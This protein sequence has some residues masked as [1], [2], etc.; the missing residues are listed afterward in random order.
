MKTKASDYYSYKFRTLL[1]M[2][3]FVFSLGYVQAQTSNTISGRIVDNNNEPV[4]GATVRIVGTTHGVLTDIDG[5]FSIDAEPGATLEVSYIG[6]IPQTIKIGDQKY[7]DLKL[8]EDVKLLEEVVVVGYGVQKKETLTGAVGNLQNDE[9]MKTKAPSLAQ[10]IQGKVAG[11]RI[12]QNNGEPGRFD[13][14]INI[15][16]F[17]TPLFIIDGVLRD[18]AGEF[19]RLNPDDIE[20]ISFLKDATAAI[21]GMNSANGVVIVTTKKG[22]KGKTRFTLNSNLAIS[23]PTSVPKMANAAQYMTM[24]NEAEINA[25]RNPYLTRDELEKWQTGAPGYKSY[26]LYDEVFNNNATQYQTTL[27]V[28]GGSDNISYFGSLGYMTD[29]SV[30]KNDALLYDKYTFRSNVTIKLTDRVTATVNIGG[31]HDTTTRPWFPF[32]DIFK[33]TRVN[34]PL[35]SVYA[36]DNP[37]YYNNFDFVPNPL[38]MIDADYTGN[39]WE[40]NKNLQTLFALEYDLPFVEGLKVKGTFAYDYNDFKNK[41]SRIGFK[42]YTYGEYT[43]EYT[44]I[45][46]NYPSLIQDRR[47]EANRI[48]LQFQT[49]YQRTFNQD[50]NLGATYVFERREERAN[51]M[52]GERK[53]DFYTIGEMDNASETGQLVSGSSEHQAYLSHIGRANYDFKGKYLAELAFRY[54]GS[55]RYAP[56]QRWAFFPFASIGWRM[57]EENFIKDNFGFV[58]NFKIRGSAGRSGQDAGDPF[59]FIPGYRLNHGGYVF[60][61]DT[62]TNGIASPVMINSNLT[63]IQVDMYNVGLDLSFLNRLIAIEFDIYQRTRSGLLAHRYGSLP[64][65]FGATLPQENLNGDRTRGVEFTISHDNKIGDFQYKVSGNFNL[66]RTQ[67]RYIEAGPFKSSMER[68]RGQLAYR[69]N[70]FI[71]GYETDGRFQNMDQ[72]NSYP[73]QNGDNGN[74]KELPGDYILKDKNGDGVVNDLDKTPLFWSGTPQVHFGLNLQASWKNFDFY[75]LLQGAA[76]YTVQFDEVY[77]KMLA[78]RGGNTPEYFYDRWHRVDPYDENSA[79]VPG[80]WPAIR[81]EQDMGSFYTRDSQIWRKDASYARLKTLEIGY[82]IDNSLFKSIGIERLRVFVNGNNLLTI[83]DPFVKAFDPERIEGDYSAG[84]NYPLSKS[85]NFGLTMNF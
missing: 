10:S 36:N 84:L 2:L 85:F 33:S 66:A 41:G 5:V 18:G 39:V 78:F 38:A 53:F 21:Y 51:W 22:T 63:W 77:A 30:L 20:S 13:S 23:S 7:L 4:I 26:D 75:T 24:R 17:G 59:Q 16:G 64:N 6:Y 62:Y 49:T 81:L 42:T 76:F 55:F 70:D 44:P 48:D 82:S 32:F 29:N 74:S 27:S 28:E 46:V 54:D 43:G 79:W 11:L 31:R 73:I 72:I 15:R 37:A 65:T 71:W 57:S 3:G 34:P 9:I 47:R 56:G 60:S 58:D 68:W 61:Q 83:S 69:W 25:G 67:N 50:H 35:T 80:K 40:T 1:L 52:N 45:D 19:Q 14:N 12:R 8:M